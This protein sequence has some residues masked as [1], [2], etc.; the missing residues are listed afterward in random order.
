M[1]LFGFGKKKE[2]QPVKQPEQ[3]PEISLP[4]MSDAAASF[5]SGLNSTPSP[6]PKDHASTPK[7][8][9][10]T[11]RSFLDRNPEAK[12]FK[13]TGKPED[14]AF[15]DV[16]NRCHVEED[17]ESD[18]KYNVTVG[19]FIIGRLP[20]SAVSYAEKIDSLPEDLA[21]II[22]DVEYDLDKDRDIISVYI[23]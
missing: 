21:V 22:S 11:V 13:L 7:T 17:N 19:G 8:Y 12:Q 2:P 14:L 20:S 18:G 1:A 16:G 23:A 15:Y 6:S 3:K 10:E 4:T 5:L 9:A